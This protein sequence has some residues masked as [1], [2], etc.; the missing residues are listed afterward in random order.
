M[1]HD[2]C[3]ACGRG[4][5]TRMRRFLPLPGPPML[6]TILAVLLCSAAPAALAADACLDQALRAHPLTG[7]HGQVVLSTLERDAGASP[8]TDTRVVAGADAGT[9][10]RGD[11]G[12]RI[13]SITKTFTAAAALR[14]HEEGRLD[15]DAP[16]TAHLPAEWMAT[17]ETDGYQPAKMTIRHLLSHTAGLADHAQ[18]PQFIET[19]K[20]NPATQW[21]PAGDVQRLVEWTDP[22]GQPGEKFAYSDTGYIMLGRIVEGITGQAL[23]DAVR[24]LLALDTRGIPHTWWERHE[25]AGDRVRTHQWYEGIDT[26]G[27][28]PSLDLFGGGGLVSPPKDLVV[29]FDALLTGK[30]FRKPE[31]L[32]LMQSTAGLPKGTPYRLGL[33]AFDFDG[34]HT[35]GHS[36]FW[37]TLVVREPV[38]GRVIAGAVTD[39]SDYPAMLGLVRSYVQA[40]KAAGAGTCAAAADAATASRE[41]ARG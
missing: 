15:L 23:P 18:A 14:L 2:Q 3:Q 30:V 37:G 24:G 12:F 33:L 5:S 34:T 38:S 19:I 7:L 8:A 20:A 10:L 40:G 17:L 36:G 21:T 27:W 16:I 28:D 13:A 31:T 39:R 35:I 22:V 26:Y 4:A 11:E 29:F 1:A 6:R 41:Q 25:A 9:P 32:A